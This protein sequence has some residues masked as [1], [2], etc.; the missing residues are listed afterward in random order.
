MPFAETLPG[1]SFTPKHIPDRIGYTLH[2][3]VSVPLVP[4][5]RSPLVH[6]MRHK[7]RTVNVER[8]SGLDVGCDAHWEPHPPGTATTAT[9]AASTA[10]HKECL[11]SKGLLGRTL[12][13]A[14]N[15]APNAAPKM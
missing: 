12:R 14:V 15:A 8:Q 1:L 10:Q 7:C 9:A 6:R 4:Q 2:Q 13:G 5:S 3:V 11:T